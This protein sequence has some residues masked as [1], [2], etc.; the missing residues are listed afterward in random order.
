MKVHRLHVRK[1]REAHRAMLD[2]IDW[3]YEVKTPFA[4]A[5]PRKQWDTP[6]Y[7]FRRITEVAETHTRHTF[8]VT[9]AALGYQ[10]EQDNPTFEELYPLWQNGTLY[11]M[12]Q[13]EFLPVYRWS[14]QAEALLEPYK[15]FVI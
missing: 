11:E 8:Q 6:V 10:I 2:S 14:K 12:V 3:N 7:A 1:R 9:L 5:F 15:N 4:A 13:T